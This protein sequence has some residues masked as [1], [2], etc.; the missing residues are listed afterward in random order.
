[1]N[2]GPAIP[3]RP[4]VSPWGP[5]GSIPFRPKC[6]IVSNV[7]EASRGHTRCTAPSPRGGEARGPTALFHERSAPFTAV[8]EVV[9]PIWSICFAWAAFSRAIASCVMASTSLR[10]TAS[11]YK[12][13][14]KHR[15]FSLGCC[16]CGHD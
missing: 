1:M 3:S 2:L 7:T 5:A 6:G 4:L 12:A 16:Y 14:T 10:S 13:P 8:L 15:S 11:S 9:P